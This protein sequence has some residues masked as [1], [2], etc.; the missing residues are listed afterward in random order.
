MLLYTYFT[1]C[2]YYSVSSLVRA[3]RHTTRTITTR[4]LATRR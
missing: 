2:E 4:A 3:G 1:T